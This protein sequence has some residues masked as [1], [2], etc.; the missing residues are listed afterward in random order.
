MVRMLCCFSLRELCAI[1]KKK[2]G[3][4]TFSEKLMYTYYISQNFRL[5]KKVGILIYLVSF[6]LLKSTTVDAAF[7]LTKLLDNF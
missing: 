2:Y 6:Y 3:I 5:L 7:S 1:S 4:K